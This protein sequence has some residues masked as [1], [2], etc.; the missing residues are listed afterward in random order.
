MWQIETEK[1][2][3]YGTIILA[4]S[5]L[6]M[7]AYIGIQANMMREDFEVNNRPWLGGF[8]F[9]VS[10]K[11]VTYSYE[12]VGKIPNTGGTL[13]FYVSDVLIGRDALNR[14]GT[15]SHPVSV[16]MP[17]QKISEVFTDEIMSTI[18]DAKEGKGDCY[19]GI[20]IHYEYG[21]Q[22]FGEYNIIA[23]YDVR[24]NNFVIVDTWT[25]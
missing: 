9:S 8:A 20:M 5:T 15:K 22:K 11:D 17:S 23:K 7:A 16:L 3:A 13:T 25:K 10:D 4:V 24:Y 1:V 19:L 2:T 6:M 14:V 18:K 12:N 21:N